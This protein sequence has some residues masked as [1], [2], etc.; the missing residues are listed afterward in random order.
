MGMLLSRKWKKSAETEQEVKVPM[1]ENSV[2]VEAV[3][4]KIVENDKKSKKV[5]KDDTPEK[6][7]PKFKK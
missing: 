4:E 6:I 5:L 3:D 7:Q 1:V 2:E